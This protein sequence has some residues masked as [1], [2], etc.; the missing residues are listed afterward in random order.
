MEKRQRRVFSA[1]VWFAL[2]PGVWQPRAADAAG[3]RTLRRRW[4]ASTTDGTRVAEDKRQSGV[5]RLLYY[6]LCT[7][8]STLHI[9]CMCVV[10]C[11]PTAVLALASGVLHA[12]TCSFAQYACVYIM[13]IT[14]SAG[15]ILRCARSECL[16]ARPRQRAG[17]AGVRSARSDGRA[18]AVQLLRCGNINTL[19][20]FSVCVPEPVLANRRFP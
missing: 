10:V 9:M 17:D 16:L 2:H 6:E 12:L 20:L 11:V 14:E 5:Q 13:P 4:A 18:G 15:D 1:Q 19:P 7:C 3:G 8:V